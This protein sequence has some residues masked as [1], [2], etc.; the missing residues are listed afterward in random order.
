MADEQHDS[1]ALGQRIRALRTAAGMT[2]RQLAGQE[3]TAA[4][5]SSIETGRL[6]PSPRTVRILARKLDSS[7]EYL[8]HGITPDQLD[9]L[10]TDL[11]A[12]RYA[13]FQGQAHEAVLRLDHLIADPI[14]RRLPE[15]Y[16]DAIAEWALAWEATGDLPTAATTLETKAA[17]AHPGERA[18]AGLIATAVRCHYRAGNS[19][20]A[21]RV[22]RTAL[23]TL[24]DQRGRWGRAGVVIASDLLPVLIEVG[25]ET[26][27]MRLANA[28]RDRLGFTGAE[29]PSLHYKAHW[30]L[31]E[32]ARIWGPIRYLIRHADD[33]VSIVLKHGSGAVDPCQTAIAYADLLLGA[34]HRET[35][36]RALRALS[37]KALPWGT[38][39]VQVVIERELL[40]ARAH[41]QLDDHDRARQV[42]NPLLVSHGA[43]LS[44]RLRGR[45][46]LELGYAASGRPAAALF[47]RAAELLAEG[48][49]S[50]EAAEAAQSALSY[51]DPA[52]STGPP[53]QRAGGAA[54]PARDSTADPLSGLRPRPRQRWQP[55]SP[56]P[57]HR[58][59]RGR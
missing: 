16:N 40:L 32:A 30:H 44:P 47:R 56:Q 31:A 19:H 46:M 26:V 6:I 7:P 51:Q 10:H 33:A 2:Q 43:D 12:A 5:I 23:A 42:L 45:L 15:L 54:N 21:I 58:R 18:W 36:A 34:Q 55:P 38:R 4:E 41:R 14:L 8:L 52:A 25:D 13:L 27:G 53:R 28:L 20:E 29:D 35:A 39:P 57:H 3:L 24:N 48:G 9:A 50:A 17:S 22:G 59:P 49:L 11:A 1:S 37:S